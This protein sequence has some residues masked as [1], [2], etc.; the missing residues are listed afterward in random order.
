MMPCFFWYCVLHFTRSVAMRQRFSGICANDISHTGS[1]SSR[2]L[3]MHAD[4]QLAAVDELLD[5]RRGAEALVDELH[6]L[7]E[8][9]LVL[10]DRGLR[11]AGRRLEEQRLDDQ[12][13]PH[14]LRQRRLCV[15]SATT[16]KS[17]TRNAVVGEQL[18]RQRLVAREDQPARVAAGVAAGAAARD[19]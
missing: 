8:L 1:T 10:D 13:E 2:S 17:G 15:R 12:R 6:A 3:P 11:D 5:D 18:L 9:V 7:R 4:V 16:V 14:R 19:S